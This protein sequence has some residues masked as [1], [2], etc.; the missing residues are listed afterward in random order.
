MTT[1]VHIF[2]RV[3]LAG[4]R[5]RIAKSCRDADFLLA[6][7]R[8]D[9]LDR[10]A[11]T[12][13]SFTNA[14]D[15]GAHDGSLTSALRAIPGMTAVVASDAS[16]AFVD[17]NCG[18]RVLADE[19]LL[20]FGD[21]AFDLAVSAL[22]LQHVNDLPGTLLQI[23]RAL[24]PDGLF[25][26]S[27]LGGETL[28]EL[29][30]AMMQAEDE[31]VGGVSPRVA[32]FAD[33]R[34]LG[35]LLQRAGFALPV[36][37]ADLVEVTYETPLHLMRDLRAMG[38]TNVMLARARKPLR[39]STLLRACEV[40]AERFSNPDGRIRATFE[41]LTMTGWVPH[42]SQQKPLQPGSARS[43]LADVLGTT[44]HKSGDKAGR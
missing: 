12:R 7:S 18:M 16:D 41:I 32:P 38:C 42:E 21:G 35:S 44:E 27:M 19:E 34:D 20:P 30:Q 6:R 36:T 31:T 5:N 3:L 4:R 8:E 43:R 33:V 2:D 28:T 25:L 15:L 17:M 26:A 9:I 29:R 37:D 13:R 24:R 22:V 23:R 39:R 11:L 1:G 10:I 14:L 40:Y